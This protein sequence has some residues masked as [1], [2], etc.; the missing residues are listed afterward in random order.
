[1]ANARTNATQTDFESIKSRLLNKVDSDIHVL[2][3]NAKR[4]RFALSTGG[5]YSSL[6]SYRKAMKSMTFE[7]YT[8]FQTH[9]DTAPRTSTR[10]I[11][12]SN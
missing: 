1:M 11:L 9:L 2:Q 12:P 10:M 5:T 8:D 7:M 6:S 3:T 4:L